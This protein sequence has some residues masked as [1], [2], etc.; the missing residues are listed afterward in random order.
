M[1]DPAYSQLLDTNQELHS[2]LQDEIFISKS[3]KKKIRFLVKE[4]EQ[5]Y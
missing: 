5:Y 4:L 1:F 2:K 3:N